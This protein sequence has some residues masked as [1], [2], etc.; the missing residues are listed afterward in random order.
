MAQCHLATYN[1][2]RRGFEAPT[3]YTDEQTKWAA[4]FGTCQSNG[5]TCKTLVPTA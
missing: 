3:K 1:L 2:I 4:N 5:S